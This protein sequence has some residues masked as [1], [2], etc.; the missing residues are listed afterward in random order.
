MEIKI[1]Y[2]NKLE[3]VRM[4]G[5][6]SDSFAWGELYR[7][8]CDYLPMQIVVY[9]KRD[10]SF[11]W[12]HFLAI[13]TYV[14]Q[15]FSAHRDQFKI[16]FDETAKAMLKNANASSYNS[17]LALEHRDINAISEKLVSIGFLRKLTDCQI[18]NL[19]KISQLPGAA[20][21]SVPG[22]GKT[23]EAL[24][25]FFINASEFDRLLVVAPKNAFGAWEEQ[26]DA[27]MG[28]NEFKFVRL[29]GGESSISTILQSKPRFMLITYD[30]LQR[31][32]KVIAETLA[33]GNVFMFL[34]ESHR[35][36]G[37]KSVKRADA[38]LELSHL[39]K[40]K[41]IMSG[42]PMPQ[43]SKDL[44]P[45][46]SYLYPTKDVTET[47]VIN[48]IQPIYVRTTKAQLGIPELTHKVV[49]VQMPQIQREIYKTL[50]SEVRRQ[51]VPYL[52]DA[53]RTELRRIGKCI[54][55]V[56]EFVSNPALLAYDIGF[57]FDRRLGELLLQSDGPKI[58]YV[59]RRAR[60]LASQNKKVIIWS[61]FVSNV[62]LIALR[63]RDLGAEYIHGGVDAGDDTDSDTR[64]GKIKRF[65]DDP[66]CMVLVANPAACSEGISLHK[67]CQYAIYLDRS[68]NAAH[69]MQSEDRIH[70]LGLAPDSHPCIEFVEC[71]NSIDQVVRE[72][73]A[74][75]VNTMAR[76]LND[77]SLTV[78]IDEVAFDEEADDVDC[79]T[80]ADAQAVLDYFFSGD[81]DD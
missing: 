21:F 52:S 65:H 19:I 77:P 67:V 8:I 76:A 54:I 47:N 12:R 41:L 39:P 15:F 34:D 71:E 5:D 78:S 32:K 58:E 66:T 64:E 74:F 45:Q 18:N 13:K 43:S 25:F 69:Y 59:C 72:R 6:A 24:A 35:I 16:V 26:M 62:E 23:T 20:T 2:L 40:R 57:V 29:Q 75:K 48:L 1:E 3:K 81:N 80:S 28:V 31:V 79:L 50:K 42:T 49:T 44:I 38:I 56:M 14:G 51:L 46:F 7:F 27:C 68:F 63:L 33:E 4:R 37:G 11:P 53:S 61:S 73:L 17:A 55:K 70:R 10:I 22:A 9:S 36:K 30:Q 60:E